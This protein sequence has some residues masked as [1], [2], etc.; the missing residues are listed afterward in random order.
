MKKLEFFFGPMANEEN[1]PARNGHLI[2]PASSHEPGNGAGVEPAPVARP[3]PGP[4]GVQWRLVTWAVLLTVLGAMTAAYIQAIW[5]QD[6]GQQAAAGPRF[7]VP[8]TASPTASPSATLAPQAQAAPGAP[9]FAAPSPTPTPVQ[10][11]RS[12]VLTPA[13]RDSGWVVSEDETILSPYDPPNHFGDSFLYTGVLDGKTYH[14]A[15][16]FDL[17]RIPRGVKVHAASLRLSGLRA[18]RLAA[19]GEWRV[20]FLAQEMDAHWR[21]HNY[22]QLQ[23][24]DLWST[25]APVLSSEQLGDGQV[26]LFEFSPDQLTLLEHRLLRGGDKSGRS[27]SFRLDGPAAGEGDN[28]FAWDSGYGPASKGPQAAPALF[29]SLGPAP[30]VTPLPYYV[31][32][33]STP[34][35]VDIQTAVAISLQKTAEAGRFGTATPLPAYWVTPVVV[36]PTPTGANPATAQAMNN[37]ATAIALTTGEPPNMATATATATYVVFTSTPTPEDIRTA[38]AQALWV[39]AQAER[40]GTATP[41]PANWV[42]PAV[43]T[44]TP[45][46]GNTATV[47]YLWA[48]ALVTGTPT[49]APGNLQTATPTP[50][51][52]TVEPVASPTATASPSPVPQAIP[53]ELMGKI[54]FLSDREGATEEERERAGR[55]QATPQVTPQ[56]YVYDPATGQFGRLTDIWPHQVAAA[57]DAWSANKLYQAYTQELLW[58]GQKKL[59]I[60]YYDYEY[61]TEQIVTEMGAGIVY[62]PVWSPVNNDLALVATES[63]NDE[64]WLIG[65]DGTNARQLTRNQWEW[66]K[67]PSWSP[68][69]Q[70]LVFFSNRTGTNQLWIMNADGSNQRPLMPANPYNDWDPVWIKYLDPPPPLARQPDWRFVKPAEETK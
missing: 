10:D 12:L 3:R 34:T 16:L 40:S 36:T 49:A 38:V 22:D 52:V 2:L 35:P 65:H 56:P 64:I 20:Q 19:G 60:H 70:Q 57:R 68:D 29:L 11:G 51:F 17:S 42:T 4:G 1:R 67:H 7:V 62:D 26:N 48:A 47:E 50:A 59:A 63:G 43:V 27:V 5:S 58:T 8:P 45:T 9:V 21:E 14:G 69:G 30:E 18:D 13:A 55:L 44:V 15:L 28:L 39:T 31:V 37:M 24:A 54:V 25:L 61:N 23:T 6:S 53:A 32:I 33:T 66:D 46:P 41:F